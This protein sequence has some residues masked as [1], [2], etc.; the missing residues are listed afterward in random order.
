MSKMF[1][2]LFTEVVFRNSALLLACLL[3]VIKQVILE[4]YR[5]VLFLYAANNVGK[6]DFVV[7]ISIIFNLDVRY[8]CVQS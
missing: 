1:V 6:S 3:L 8:V 5:V 2:C 7:S 4:T